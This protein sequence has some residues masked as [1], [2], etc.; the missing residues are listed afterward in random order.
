V[1]D[2]EL[3]D[4][5][6]LY[7]IAKSRKRAIAR[8]QLEQDAPRL[9]SAVPSL[10]TLRLSITEHHV[11]HPLQHVKHIVVDRAPA[12][13]KLPCHDQFCR[14]GG[15]DVTAFVMR[16][17]R[18]REAQFS[19]TQSCEGRVGQHPCRRTMTFEV[20]ARYEEPAAAE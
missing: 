14:E 13:F 12:L 16:G 5:F 10:R 3:L 8:R 17:L 2:Q 20:T 15:Y 18:A 11:L 1:E 19:G 7:E 9:A 4:E 6:Q